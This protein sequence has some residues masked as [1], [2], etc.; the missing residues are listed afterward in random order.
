RRTFP[1]VDEVVEA[2]VRLVPRP[3]APNPAWSGDAPDPATSQAPWHGYNI[4]NSQPVEVPEVV[5]LIE[6]AVGKPAVRE[7]LPIQPG[8]V[9]E[10]C[11]DTAELE[12]GV[13]VG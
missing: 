7:L 1:Y 8:D 3:P 2:V 5:R 6:Q 13:G 9:P 4:G 10:T 12:R 11:A